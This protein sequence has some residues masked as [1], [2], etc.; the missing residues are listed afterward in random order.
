[1]L[2]AFFSPL[3]PAVVLLLGAF[4]L[5]LLVLQFSPR[6]QRQSGLRTLTAPVLVGLAAVAVLGVR[7]TFGTDAAGEGLE[8]LSGWDFSTPE[9]VT[10]LT[11][12]ADTLSL[13]FLLLTVLI[14]LAVT[15]ATPL[16]IPTPPKREENVSDLAIWLALGAG[17][18]FLFVSA[19]GLTLVYTVLGFDVLTMF[20]WLQRGQRELSIARLLLGV[21]SVVA[22]MLASLAPAQEAGSGS[23]WPGLALWLRL[24]LYPFIE[25]NAHTRWQDYGGLAYL[26]LS[27]MVGIYLAARVMTAPLMGIVAWAVVIFILLNSLLAWLTDE[28]PM[29]LIRLMLV[30]AAVLLLVVPLSQEAVTASTVG[31]IL[32]VVILWI[33]PRLGQPRLSEG[34]WSWPYLPA[35]AATLTLIGLPFSLGWLAR[36]TVYQTLLLRENTTLLL[37]VVLAE[38]LVLSGLV[39]Y[40]LRLWQGD[41]HSE[42]RSMVAIIAMVPFLIPG[43]APLI[44]SALTRTNLPPANFAQPAGVFGALGVTLIGAFGLGYFRSQLIPRLRIDPTGLAEFAGLGWLLPWWAALLNWL[45]KFILLIRIVLEGQHYMGWAMFAALVGI[46]IILLGA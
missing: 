8:L 38:G 11:I 25:A 19:N 18:A 34:A 3:A 6:W 42:R 10:T 13:P 23:L 32:S 27:L 43:L 40:W 24:G 41:E 16:I 30:E 12:R 29:V 22:L 2:G 33:T 39:R 1:M 46:L 31:L 28:H 7:L 26:G 36:T 5:P 4:I 35:V 44:L 14:L 9:T 20:Y 21:F 17:T 15:L 37:A 45:G